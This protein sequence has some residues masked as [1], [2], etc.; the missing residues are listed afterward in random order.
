MTGSTSELPV[1][2]SMWVEGPLTY[3]EQVCLKSALSVGHQVVLY[4]YWD[5]TGVPDG[6]IV[7][8]GRE[9]M[10]ESSLMKHKKR[11]SWS[12]SS[13]IFRYLLLQQGR[14][15]WIDTDV[16]FL[17]PLEVNRKDYLFG[18]QKQ[19]LLNGA[20]LYAKKDSPLIEELLAFI[21]L[22]YII[23]PWLPVRKRF[24]YQIRPWIGLRPLSLAEHRWGVIGPRA[25]TYFADQLGLSCHAERQDVFYPVPPKQAK[26]FFDPERNIEDY[27]TS[28]TVAVHLWNEA[29]K[30]LKKSPAPAGSYL[31]K[32]CL[33]HGVDM[34]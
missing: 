3:V 31:N 29:I 4:A 15:V 27:I 5:V 12:L 2:N 6:V 33:L 23:P 17:K 30:D 19:D 11:N 8:D 9:I 22:P 13:N 34:G 14:G 25:I 26:A 18:W 16:Y 1:L 21:N 24:A 10:P 20:I 7:R 28:D 32:I